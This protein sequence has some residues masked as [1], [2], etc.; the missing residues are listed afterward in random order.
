[1]GKYSDLVKDFDYHAKYKDP[2]VDPLIVGLTG[3]DPD[4]KVNESEIEHEALSGLLGGDV[5]GH[6]H[7]NYEQLSQLKTFQVKIDNLATSLQNLSAGLSTKIRELEDG[8]AFYQEELDTAVSDFN[9]ARE[10]LTARLDAIAGQ[11]TEDTE[12]LD[13][14][15][16]AGNV[17]HVNLGDNIRNIHR[18]LLDY[19]EFES[20]F[21]KCRDDDLQ[22]QVNELGEAVINEMHRFHDALLK[23]QGILKTAIEDRRNKD[24]NIYAM[25]D[26]IG[27]TCIN[28][29]HGNFIN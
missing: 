7:I 3:I 11:S 19:I 25:I 8:Q 13:A 16:D 20:Q 15:V 10:G 4:E 26:E 9:E 27:E 5:T 14:R 1:M 24:K 6:Y 18:A 17:T 22:E 28:I 23:Y 21:R 29:M 2:V 12:I